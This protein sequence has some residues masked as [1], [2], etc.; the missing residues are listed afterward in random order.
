MV[1]NQPESI[2]LKMRGHKLKSGVNLYGE[3]KQKG[4]KQTGI[5]EGLGVLR[6]G[7]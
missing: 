7:L 6:Y 4:I 2:N 5:E 1:I 3:L